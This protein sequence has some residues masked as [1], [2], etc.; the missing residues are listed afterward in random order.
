MKNGEFKTLSPFVDDKGIIRVG[1]RIDKAIMSYEEKHPVLLPSKYRISLLITNHMHN[2]GHPGIA[3]TTAKTRRKY[4][5][6]KAS[7]LSKAVKFTCVTCREMAH[8]A[9]TQL[10]ADLPVLR[11]APQTPPFHY[12]ACD[13]FGPFSVKVGRNKRAQHYG[14]I[15]PCLNTRAVHLEMAVDLT[16][17][18]FIQVL[19]RFFSIRGYLAVLLRDNRCRWLVLLENYAKWSK[20]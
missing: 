9:E 4:W 6:L 11:L 7:K 15:L 16:T 1:G 19:R 12:T 3:T 18:E 5:I 8:K 14:A 10:M 13:Y 20:V 17:M 2:Q